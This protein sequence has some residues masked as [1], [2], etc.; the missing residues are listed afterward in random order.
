MSN[1]KTALITGAARRIGAALT[2]T[3][4]DKGYNVIIHYRHSK[5]EALAL[6]EKCCAKRS[7]SAI[8]FYADLDKTNDIEALV[9]QTQKAFNRLD[10]VI[11]NA[12]EFLL[13]PMGSATEAQWMALAKSNLM[14]PFFMAQAALSLL[15][16][17]QGCII[18]MTDTNVAHPKRGYSAYISMKAGL[19]TLTR[20]L[21]LEF[22]PQ[23]RVNAIAL[24]PTLWPEGKNTLTESLQKKVLEKIPMQRLPD[25]SEVGQTVLFLIENRYLT[26]EIITLDGGKSL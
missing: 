5:K 26:G 20:A 19:N 3:L 7:Q 24:G 16:K 11:N 9:Q 21:A 12:S 25:L 10:V 14:A 4:H 6:A 8:A 2:E 13:T 18:N 17:T 15:Q 22:A 23:V 1:H